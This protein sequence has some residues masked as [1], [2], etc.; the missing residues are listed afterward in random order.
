M[1]LRRALKTDTCALKTR[2]LRARVD[3]RTRACAWTL[4]R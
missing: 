2:V 1:P 4:G 3:A